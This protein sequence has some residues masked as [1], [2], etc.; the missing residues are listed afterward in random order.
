M[1]SLTEANTPRSSP[2]SFVAIPREALNSKTEEGGQA[3]KKSPEQ[4]VN[5]AASASFTKFKEWPVAGR[6]MNDIL[7]QSLWT[8]MMSLLSSR[9]LYSR[10]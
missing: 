7:P 1:V 6:S 2:N 10:A 3:Y 5:V 9:G 8:A 4:L